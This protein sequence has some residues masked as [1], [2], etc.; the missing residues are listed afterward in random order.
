MAENAECMMAA[1]KKRTM[2]D[3]FFPARWVELPEAP[4]EFKDVV[5][6]HSTWN[7]DWKDRLRV[8]F[9]GRIKCQ[10]KIVCENAVGATMPASVYWAANPFEKEKHD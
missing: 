6:V 10:M 9:S 8:L 2:F 1:P 7:L 4:A 5:C 3:R